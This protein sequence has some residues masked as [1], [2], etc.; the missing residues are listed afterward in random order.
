MAPSLRKAGFENGFLDGKGWAGARF[1]P[2]TPTPVC[3]FLSK[4]SLQGPQ[5][6]GF[7]SLEAGPVPLNLEV[8]VG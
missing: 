2:G 7:A 3:L 4:S 1:N 5:T 8:R 6:L